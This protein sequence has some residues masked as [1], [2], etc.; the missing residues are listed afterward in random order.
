MVLFCAE[1]RAT[2]IIIKKKKLKHAQH[3][4]VLEARATGVVIGNAY[5]VYHYWDGCYDIV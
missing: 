5:N 4:S 1:T 2:R 3:V